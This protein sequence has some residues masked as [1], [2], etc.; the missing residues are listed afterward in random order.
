MT[1]RVGIDIVIGNSTVEKRSAT[2]FAGVAFLLGVVVG[3]S[4]RGLRITYLKKKHEF[5]KRHVK[6]TEQQLMK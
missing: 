4:I 6:K 1:T 3:Y 2:I 5:L